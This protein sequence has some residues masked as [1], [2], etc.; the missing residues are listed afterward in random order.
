[1]R[2]FS[3][4]SA[5][6]LLVV[7]LV[8]SASTQQPKPEPK[9]LT[10]EQVEKLK[11]RAK[12]RQSAFD[13]KKAGQDNDVIATLGKALAITREVFGP[14][15]PQVANAL[16]EIAELH[17]QLHNWEAARTA[18][19]QATDILVARYGKDDW[20]AIDAKLALADV[21]VFEKMTKEELRESVRADE[22]W[23]EGMRL[24]RQL[25]YDDACD[26]FI[27]MLEINRKLF[28]EQNLRVLQS[29][30]WLAGAYRDAGNHAKAEP[31]F[32]QTIAIARQVVGDRHPLYAINLGNL[33]MEY[34]ET[35]QY[36]KAELPLRLAM[37]IRRELMG[38]T[39]PDYGRALGNL[40][41]LYWKT[42]DFFQAGVHYSRVVEIYRNSLGEKH[43]RYIA[44]LANLA[45]VYA[46]LS[47]YAKAEPLFQ[48]V[49]DFQ[50]ETLGGNHPTYAMRLNDLGILYQK[51][52]EYE[53]GAPL[54]EKAVAI[55]R[56]TQGE[57][58]PNYALVLSDLAMLY[59]S[60]GEPKKAEPLLKQAMEIREKN[61]GVTH[62]YYAESLTCLALLY[63]DLNEPTK[64]ESLLKQAISIHLD[65]L[66]T[67]SDVQS[68]QAQILFAQS[69]V[70]VLFAYQRAAAESGVHSPSEAY[71]IALRW[72]GQVFVRQRR[73]RELALARR[74]PRTAKLAA[75]LLATTRQLAA[76]FGQTSTAEKAVEW[77]K[78][79]A[80]LS[81]QREGI[82]RELTR[83]STRFRQQKDRETMTPEQL[84]NY[85]PTNTALVDFLVY[86]HFTPNPKI[87][88]GGTWE[89][90]LMAFIVA[91]E[92]DV[93]RIEL[94]E[95]KLISE[96]IEN[97][98]KD[99]MRKRPVLDDDDPAAVL[100]DKLW[101]PIAKHL[102]G[103]S[104]VLI[105]PDQDLAK[106]PFAA[107]P[108]SKD[109]TYLIEQIEIAVLPVPQF[110]P[111]LLTPLPAAAPSLLLIGDVDY[112]AALA[113]SD[114]GAASQ[115]A[116]RGNRG[117]GVWKALPA[118]RDE[119]R[120]IK[121]SYEAAFP[122]QPAK[123]MRAAEPSEE[124]VRREIG[125]YR[126]IHFATH[127]F[128]SPL[129]VRGAGPGQSD[130]D[131]TLRAVA[132]RQCG[133]LSGIVLAGANKPLDPATGGDDGILTAAEV[134]TLDMRGVEMVV[135][136]A[137][138]TG[139]GQTAVGS[140]EG[141]LGLQRAFQIAGARS[142]VAS[143]WEVPD[144]AT[145][146][147]MTRAY[148][149][150]WGGKKSKLDG[151]IEA[152]RRMLKEGVPGPEGKPAR[153]RTPPYFWAAFVLSGDWR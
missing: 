56:S 5:C 46:S 100:R 134:G 32:Q 8:G 18:H 47:D 29:L 39:H 97:W 108:G 94:G 95:F 15:D 25:K 77:R 99:T 68:E 88:G 93:V 7:G 12:L 26:R 51:S 132:S 123:T 124:A 48:Q 40:A 35:G 135:L 109:G 71:A 121:D 52:G 60:A 114:V 107:L 2:T 9:K 90:R 79:V 153:G 28:G 115:I 141:L 27:Q 133:L 127:G 22:L 78:Q 136:S 75:D 142:V 145:R 65:L 110:L 43:P 117:G 125:R 37:T 146:A 80:F 66:D 128:F 3:R 150:W 19:S 81:N 91:P 38:D 67:T 44:S 4:W 140:G 96:A 144:D 151:L 129:N 102:E 31:L 74:D 143:L 138:E 41:L 104:T 54:L 76:I 30:N 14:Q 69:A 73:Q 24:Q 49:V 20:R 70:D 13:Y 137:C 87:K 61:L 152:Q 105:S 6:L 126:F 72:K 63:L 23:N 33:G 85:L 11:E 62:P 149:N 119:V 113:N 148:E 42:G 120:A 45:N 59:R 118:T 103:V 106:L 1:M 131:P 101:N 116:N 53:K 21:A 112:G 98:R 84:R 139:L 55:I 86:S 147:L 50:R 10:P 130:V 36:L 64:A 58:H 57:G 16:E 92:H 83:L 82:E 17:M 111:D 89:E 34:L 122:G